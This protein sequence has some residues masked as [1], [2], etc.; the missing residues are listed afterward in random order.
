VPQVRAGK[1]RSIGVTTKERSRVV[2][3]VPTFSESGVPGYETT[4]WYGILAPARTP[5]A[6]VKRMN[7]E[8]AAAL[9]NPEVVEKLST[10]GVEP[11]HTSPEQFAAFIQ[12]E[13]VKWAK[14]IKA[15][16]VKND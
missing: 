9:K 16:D 4:Q 6:I 14:V 8:L 15:S 11:F 2:P 7:S 5:D 10:Q 13:V 12:A 3:E 1:L